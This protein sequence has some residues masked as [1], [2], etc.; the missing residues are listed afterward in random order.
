MSRPPLPSRSYVCS[1]EPV[2]DQVRPDQLLHQ[3]VT[4]PILQRRC[5]GVLNDRHTPAGT[6]Q[7]QQGGSGAAPCAQRC[8]LVQHFVLRLHITPLTVYTHAGHN[9]GSQP[10][11]GTTSTASL[12]LQHPS[13]AADIPVTLAFLQPLHLASLLCLDKLLPC[14]IFRRQLKCPRD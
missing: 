6:T 9:Q 11:A 8:V 10:W 3:D 12:L 4:V 14:F 7:Q 2:I 13:T 1:P 5:R